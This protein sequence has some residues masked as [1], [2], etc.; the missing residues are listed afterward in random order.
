MISLVTAFL[1]V[2]MGLCLEAVWFVEQGM[3]SV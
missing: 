3:G 1:H 2:S